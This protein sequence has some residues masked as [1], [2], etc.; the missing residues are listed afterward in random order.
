MVTPFPNIVKNE[1]DWHILLK[2]LKKPQIISL[3]NEAD[4]RINK[5]LVPIAI[6]QENLICI[7]PGSL[8]VFEFASVT[9]IIVIG[10]I[11]K[12]KQRLSQRYILNIKHPIR[13]YYDDNTQLECIIKDVSNR[14]MGLYVDDPSKFAPNTPL[15]LI[16]HDKEFKAQVS[17][18]NKQNWIG[19]KYDYYVGKTIAKIFNLPIAKIDNLETSKEGFRAEM[20]QLRETLLSAEADK[21]T[22]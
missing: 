6:N 19:V 15:K 12:G 8:E 17:H 13:V 14:G 21:D 3:R 11:P 2:T 18:N 10:D 7:R 5:D 16:I 9:D 20:E 22:G 1:E 4:G